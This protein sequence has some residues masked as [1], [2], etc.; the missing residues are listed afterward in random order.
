[1]K[2]LVDS[3]VFNLYRY[4]VAP[5]G[6]ADVH[7]SIVVLI[8]SLLLVFNVHHRNRSVRAAQRKVWNQPSLRADSV[9]LSHPSVFVT[10]RVCLPSLFVRFNR[11]AVLVG[12]RG[13]KF[14]FHMILKMLSTTLP[15]LLGS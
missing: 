7:P 5:V 14:S 10:L 6:S 9:I 2:L 3:R 1:M 8:T 4:V 11:G 15:L 13:H 12:T